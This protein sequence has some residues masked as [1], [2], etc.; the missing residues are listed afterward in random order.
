VRRRDSEDRHDGIADELLDHSAVAL[1]HR[2]R[3]GEVALHYA[4]KRFGVEPLP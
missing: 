3:L 1:E 4:P 2:P